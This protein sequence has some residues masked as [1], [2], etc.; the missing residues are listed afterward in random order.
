VLTPLEK[1]ARLLHNKSHSRLHHD[2]N[3]FRWKSHF[4]FHQ[5]PSLC[6]ATKLM[7]RRHFPNTRQLLSHSQCFVS[8]RAG[9]LK[10]TPGSVFLK[11]NY[12]WAQH[13]C[14]YRKMERA[15][16]LDVNFTPSRGK[17]GVRGTQNAQSTS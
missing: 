3:S 14:G 1:A 7:L 2:E 4:I 12:V 5:Q 10:T 13:A 17:C 16:G 9:R 15:R 11:C 6:F 8:L